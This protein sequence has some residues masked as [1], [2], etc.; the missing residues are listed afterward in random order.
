MIDKHVE[1]RRQRKIRKSMT[2]LKEEAMMSSSL[3]GSPQKG[4]WQL[5]D[6]GDGL[7]S[8]GSL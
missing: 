5:A 6:S 1:A 8:V 4:T 2:M 3:M 7:R